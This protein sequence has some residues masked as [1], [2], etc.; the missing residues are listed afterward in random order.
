MEEKKDKI[1]IRVATENGSISW[2]ELKER[3]D[4][5][6]KKKNLKNFLDNLIPDGIA[7][8]AAHHALS[9]PWLIVDH[10]IDELKWAWQRVFRG[11]DDRAAWSAD[12]YFAKMISEVIGHLKNHHHGYPCILENENSA[13]P[14]SESQVFAVLDE[15]EKNN[16]EKKDKEWV[17]ILEKIETGFKNYTDQKYEWIEPEGFEE[18]F[19]LFRKYFGNLW[20]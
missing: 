9:R 1:N 10:W 6:A 2:E 4:E 3:M 19:D 14:E 7:G 12:Y 20:D 5:E 11:W 13:F 18:A 17:E 16:F 15:K 8:Y